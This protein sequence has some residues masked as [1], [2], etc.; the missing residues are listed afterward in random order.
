MK[1][2]LEP[3]AW[4]LRL[5]GKDDAGPF[6]PYEAAATVTVDELRVATVR[7]LVMDRFSKAAWLA[8]EAAM[9]EA[10]IEAMIWSRR[11]NGKRRIVRGPVRAGKQP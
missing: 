4:V 6:D 5:H 11:R 10:G 7:G 9:A 8:I 3:V 2:Y 1:A